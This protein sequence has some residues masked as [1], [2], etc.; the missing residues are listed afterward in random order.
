[1]DEIKEQDEQI[2][3]ANVVVGIDEFTL[4]LQIVKRVDVM[5]W[6]FHA[7][8]LIEEFVT[9]S[10]VEDVFGELEKSSDNLVQGYNLGYLL[11]T[12]PF[13]F[14]ICFHTSHENMGICIKMSSTAYMT[15]K[16]EYL[17]KYGEEMNLAKFLRMVKSDNYS[18]SLSRVDFT[19]DYF[20]F[21]NPIFQNQ[22]LHPDTIYNCLLKKTMQVVDGKGRS[23]IKVWSGLNKNGEYQTVYVGSKKS[24]TKTFLRIYDKKAEQIEKNGFRC[25]EALD[26]ES[27]VRFEAV[28]K[29]E[30]SRQ[31]T[32]LLMN[33]SIIQSKDDLQR[34]IAGKILDK[35]IFKFTAND[36]ITDFTE[37]LIEIVSGK[38]YAPLECASP[39]DNSLFQSL[40]YIIKNSGLLITL[41][42]AY[43]VYPNQDAAREILDW[44]YNMFGD[45]YLGKI[46]KNER[47]EVHKWLKKHR[48]EMSKETLKEVLE[49]VEIAI[50]KEEEF[51]WRARK[52][53]STGEQERGV[54]NGRQ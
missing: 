34:F 29:G 46:M 14:S 9:L 53:N 27:W 2:A 28:Y 44:I 6:A 11:T 35:Y 30:Y 51:P 39:R 23:N 7:E 40:K 10:K 54:E 37:M 5:T 16:Q 19:A 50:E 20:N 8:E 18:Q 45:Y 52:K 36:E 31:I 24:N 4:V 47:H 49:S 38:E 22:Y 13:Y 17:A 21:P 32:K 15:Y 42:K 33:E 12:R 26:C 1:M 43:F 48:T 3:D 41:A 25:Q